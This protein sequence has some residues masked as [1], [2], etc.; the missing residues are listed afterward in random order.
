[1]VV[2]AVIAGAITVVI[3][4]HH[5]SPAASSPPTLPPSS[6][7][8]T[9]PTTPTTGAPQSSDRDASI[10][11]NLALGPT[12][13]AT[14]VA[15]GLVDN[16]NLVGPNNGESTLDL[17]NSRY[18][19]EA[20][21][22]ARY[23]TGVADNN[24]NIVFSTEAVLYKT[25]GGTAEA[26]TEL[27]SVSANCPERVVI[28]PVGDPP[29][30]TVF[31]PAPDLFWP[32]TPTVGRQAYTLAITDSAGTT[33]HSIAVYLR[34]G[35]VLLGLYFSNPSGAQPAIDG[36]TT[37]PG[38]VTLFAGRMAKIPTPVILSGGAQI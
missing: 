18:Q 30:K 23:Q 17:C 13:V 33:T 5:H 16:G 29:V 1:M 8:T 32:Q 35:R 9:L 4:H 10:L 7:R 21:R 2:V 24:G 3:D 6:P 11:P 36:Q 37:I 31:G 15:S 28:S 19:S 26:F 25:P 34:R 14:G 22:S 20:Q 38:I 12:D 27:R